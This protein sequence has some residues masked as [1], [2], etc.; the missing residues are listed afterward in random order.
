MITLLMVS[1]ILCDVSVNLTT[2]LEE[3][4]AGSELK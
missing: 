2:D 1:T 4:Q 3:K